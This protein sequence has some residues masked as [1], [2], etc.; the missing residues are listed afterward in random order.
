MFTKQFWVDATERA[1]KTAGQFLATI[2]TVAF[3]P[4]LVSGEVAISPDFNYW[5]LLIVPAIGAVYSYATSIASKNLGKG[6]TKG[7]PSLVTPPVR[8]PE[9][10]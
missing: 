8:P 10:L 9:F 5:L 7:S 1:L 2:L 4:G 6:D 3:G